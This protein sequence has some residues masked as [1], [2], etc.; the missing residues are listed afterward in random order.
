VAQPLFLFR[1]GLKDG[2]TLR[3]AM[4]SQTAK[5]F[6]TQLLLLTAPAN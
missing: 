1:F 3:L 6:A 2:T 4:S 5:H